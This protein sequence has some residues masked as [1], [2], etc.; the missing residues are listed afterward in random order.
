MARST[1]ILDECISR[2]FPEL[3]IKACSTIK[4][5]L[6]PRTPENIRRSMQMNAESY[7]NKHYP[8]RLAELRSQKTQRAAT[9]SENRSQAYSGGSPEATGKTAFYAYVYGGS[10]TS[11]V[12][13]QKVVRS[14]YRITFALHPASLEAAKS[15]ACAAMENDSSGRGRDCKEGRKPSNL[16]IVS[17]ENGGYFALA[18]AGGYLDGAAGAVG[19]G[20]ATKKQA[21]DQAL[22]LCERERAKEGVPQ[23]C[24]LTVAALNDGRYGGSRDPYDPFSGQKFQVN[25]CWGSD[26]THDASEQ[27]QWEKYCRESASR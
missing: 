12:A 18:E 13:G 15:I 19:C 16:S 7:L 8:D 26:R 6:L 20:F 23:P 5:G 21:I 2:G 22:Q 14:N 4:Q 25:H 1:R 11:Y 10:H 9:P 27:H 3:L 24:K 17:C